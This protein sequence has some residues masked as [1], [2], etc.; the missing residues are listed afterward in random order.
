MN[1]PSYSVRKLSKLAGVTTR[2]LR[3]YDQIGLL[4]PPHIADNGYRLYTDE[5]L[6]RMQQIL[7]YRELGFSLKDIKS[8]LESPKFDA[9]GALEEH[10]KALRSRIDRLNRL[11]QTIDYTISNLKGGTDM[12]KKKLFEGFSEEKQKKYER[13]IRDRY[14][15]KAFDGVKDWN[16]YSAEQKAKILEEQEAIYR[17]AVASISKPV[18]SPEVQAIVARWHQHLRYFYEPSL[19]RMAGLAQLY[20]EHPD[21]LKNFTKMHPKMPR[22]WHDAICHYVNK[23]AGHEVKCEGG[24]W[25]P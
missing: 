25:M 17:D 16:R 10:G 23:L 7:F 6:F 1:G 4:K 8:I 15:D 3:Y 19:E 14:G 12:D 21:F 5:S 24:S 11:V 9:L 20:T 2:T 18:D 13:E 22:F